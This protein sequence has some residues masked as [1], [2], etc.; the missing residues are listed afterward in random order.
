MM[1]MPSLSSKNGPHTSRCIRILARFRNGGI[2]GPP[3]NCNDCPPLSCISRYIRCFV[4]LSLN[5]SWVTTMRLYLRPYLITA[6]SSCTFTFALWTDRTSNPAALRYNLRCGCTSAS[7]S[8]RSSLGRRADTFVELFVEV[9]FKIDGLLEC[10]LRN[11][12]VM[13]R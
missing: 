6:I 10:N 12:G 13:F 4:F 8:K 7:S 5:R 1:N 9:F 3:P 11:R 2:S